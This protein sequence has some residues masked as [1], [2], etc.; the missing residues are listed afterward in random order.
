M[1]VLVFITRPASGR[2]ASATS[3]LILLLILVMT[4]APAVAAH[5]D[6]TVAVLSE[7][8]I[9]LRVADPATAVVPLMTLLI[10]TI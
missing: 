6:A 4:A 7:T 9:M 2:G 5:G 8:A 10:F 3:A 1:L